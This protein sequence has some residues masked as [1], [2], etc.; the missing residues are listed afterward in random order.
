MGFVVKMNTY[1]FI[2]NVSD[3][4][5]LESVILVLPKL[6]ASNRRWSILRLEFS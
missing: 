2:L 6:P 4:F 3:T 1:K 5:E